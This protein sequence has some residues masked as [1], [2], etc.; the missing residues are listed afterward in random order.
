ML[1]VLK[2]LES[3]GCIDC[4]ETNPICLDFDHVKGSKFLGIS[5]MVHASFSYKKILIEMNKCVVRCANCHRKK[6][7]QDHEWYS[8]IDFDNMTVIHNDAKSAC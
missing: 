4:G 7:A 3:H 8:Y 5:Q 6:T 1:N 2:H